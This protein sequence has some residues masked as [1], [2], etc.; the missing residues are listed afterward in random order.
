MGIKGVR[1]RI[2]AGGAGRWGAGDR[3]PGCRESARPAATR[4]FMTLNCNRVD[5][6]EIAL[7]FP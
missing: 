6:L 5:L 3:P 2:R 1:L 7:A 4:G